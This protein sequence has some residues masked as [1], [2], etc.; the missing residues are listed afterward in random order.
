MCILNKNFL[1]IL[2]EIYNEIKKKIG[3]VLSF[4]HHNIFESS[5]NN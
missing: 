1:A 3:N 5:A 4:E 2:E